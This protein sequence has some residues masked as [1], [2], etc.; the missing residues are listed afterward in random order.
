M[1]L[2]IKEVE[3]LLKPQPK[4]YPRRVQIGPFHLMDGNS[5]CCSRGCGSPTQYQ[6]CGV[7]Y[8][9]VH[10]VE[11]LNKMVVILASDKGWHKAFVKAKERAA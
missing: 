6:V 5:R 4:K 1:S 3:A 7:W 8:C 10:A 9:M 2:S 11:L